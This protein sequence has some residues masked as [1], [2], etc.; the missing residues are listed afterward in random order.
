MINILKSMHNMIQLKV[1]G[2]P[3][4]FASKIGVSQS[5]LYNYIKELKALGAPIKYDKT[6]KSYCYTMPVHFVLECQFISIPAIDNSIMTNIPDQLL[7]D[8]IY[9]IE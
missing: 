5:T 3:V 8:H 9:G 7:W 6:H 1:T 4:A 2:G